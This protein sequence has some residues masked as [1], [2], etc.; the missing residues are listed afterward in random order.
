M[1]GGTDLLSWIEEGLET[2]KETAKDQVKDVP[3]RI[4]LE[5]HAEV[6]TLEGYLEDLRGHIGDGVA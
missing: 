5:V 3:Y 2:H 4:Q 1:R 6:H